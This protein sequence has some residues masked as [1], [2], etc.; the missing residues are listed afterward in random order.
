[1]RRSILERLTPP[2][3]DNHAAT[4]VASDRFEIREDARRFENWEFNYAAVIGLGVAVDYALDWGIAAI[5]A[6]VTALAARLLAT[7]P[8]WT[9]AELKNAIIAR[10][11]L[12]DATGVLASR[13]GV[14]DPLR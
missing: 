3:L 9:T 14:L 4:W 2:V 6:R 8:D 13:Y 5:E 12:T 11:R 1:M 10:A 7:N